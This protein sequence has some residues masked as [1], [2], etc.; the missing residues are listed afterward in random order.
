M[1]PDQWQLQVQARVQARARVLIKSSG[2][3]S[4]DAATARLEPV[5][6]IAAFVKAARD[7]DPALP[8]AVLPHGPYCVPVPRLDDTGAGAGR[9]SSDSSQVTSGN[10]CGTST[11]SWRGSTRTA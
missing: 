3:S 10:S 1:V 5:D 6:D 4:A 11:S 7:T 2:L 9:Y 8:I